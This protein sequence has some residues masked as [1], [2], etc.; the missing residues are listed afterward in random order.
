MKSLVQK[1]PANDKCLA[2]CSCLSPD[3]WERPTSYGWRDSTKP[4]ACR[5]PDKAGSRVLQVLF[6]ARR[7]S[8]KHD[9]SRRVGSCSFSASSRFASKTICSASFK[10]SRASSKVLP[11]VNPGI[12]STQ[13]A[14]QSPTC[15]MPRSASCSVSSLDSGSL[16]SRSRQTKS[17]RNPWMNSLSTICR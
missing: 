15:F 11:G 5:L 16:S 9:S 12:S 14:H 8:S 2:L 17:L 6:R 4:N 13:A 1:L 7:A 10:F 3:A